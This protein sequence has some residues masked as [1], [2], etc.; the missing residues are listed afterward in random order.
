LKAISQEAFIDFERE[1]WLNWRV[2]ALV[3]EKNDVRKRKER[4]RKKFLTDADLR[5]E[6]GCRT[7]LSLPL[8]TGGGGQKKGKRIL[9]SSARDSPGERERHLTGGE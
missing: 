4:K 6:E 9:R 8:E 3:S 2:E 1:S 5:G 7:F